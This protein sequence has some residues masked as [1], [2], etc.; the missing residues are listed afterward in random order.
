M[1]NTRLRYRIHYL[2]A[3]MKQVRDSLPQTLNIV[4]IE[5]IQSCG[6]QTIQSKYL[7]EESRYK[8]SEQEGFR[9]SLY[10]KSQSIL[11]FKR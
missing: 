3:G 6:P 11:Y 2:E 9:L 4:I 7:R 8:I 1:D 5:T 10:F